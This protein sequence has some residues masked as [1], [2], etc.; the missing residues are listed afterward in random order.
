MAIARIPAD[1]RDRTDLS[2]GDLEALVALRK[3]R[4]AL[5]DKLERLDDEVARVREAIEKNV[6]DEAA[7]LASD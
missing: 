2:I 7:L 3:S 1:V 4:K 6:A 5:Q